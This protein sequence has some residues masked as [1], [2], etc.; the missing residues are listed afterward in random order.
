MKGHVE[1]TG[2]KE[3]Q[4]PVSRL[5]A[6][7]DPELLAFLRDQVDSFVK[8]DLIHFF[9]E[10][11]HTTDTA[12]NIAL[13]IGRDPGDIEVELDDLVA[14]GVLVAHRLGE[15]RV[16]ALSPDPTIWVRIRRF[17]K[18]CSD[19]EFRIRAIYHVV[20]GLR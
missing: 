9:Y 5:M 19:R 20:R 12:S 18:A 14:R 11:P 3:A 1:R 6:D 15:M 4:R 17:I 2:R 13:Y 7:V 8:W 16:Y 10:N